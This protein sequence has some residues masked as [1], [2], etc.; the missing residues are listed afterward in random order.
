MK[1]YF[2]V[3]NKRQTLELDI[4]ENSPASRATTEQ[5]S[6]T[7]KINLREISLSEYKTLTKLYT[8]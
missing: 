7:L 2:E 1:R 3:L 6:E 5:L 4:Q 8:K